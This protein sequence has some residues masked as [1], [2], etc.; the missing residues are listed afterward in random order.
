MSLLWLVCVV[1][2]G[3]RKSI[4]AER[5]T[6]EIKESFYKVSTSSFF[7]C[8]FNTLDLGKAVY[9][10]TFCSRSRWIWGD[11]FVS[12]LT[13]LS[14]NKIGDSTGDLSLSYFCF[15]DSLWPFAPIAF[16]FWFVNFWVSRI[17]WDTFWVTNPIWIVLGFENFF[18]FSEISALW[19]WTVCGKS[20]YPHL[21]YIVQ[22]GKYAVCSWLDCGNLM[23]THCVQG[24][25]ADSFW[26]FFE[27]KFWFVQ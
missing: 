3:R 15:L 12:A 14:I 13:D 5:G 26:K 4:V 19:L 6:T 1:V 27:F 9:S 24:L 17:P 21:A 11:R 22:C 20:E 10:V 2:I 25:P 7:S 8:P 23:Y 16:V 18:M